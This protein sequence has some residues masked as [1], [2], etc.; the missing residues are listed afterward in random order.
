MA[1]GINQI[2][3]ISGQFAGLLLGGLLAAW[4]WRAVFWVNVPVGVF[5]TIW[6]YVKLHDT[7]VRRKARMDWWGNITFAL[8]L[9]SIL[10][11]I[12]Y[13]IQPY[14][15]HTMGWTSPLVLFC[16]LGGI[17]LHLRGDVRDVFMGW[18]RQQRP[19]LL[20]RYQELYR[21]GAYA[22]RE[23]RERLS[24]LV[25]RRG[26]DPGFRLAGHPTSQ[27]DTAPSEPAGR[28]EALF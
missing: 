1:L 3:G 24:R 4:D 8:G 6:A 11:G 2:A 21:R 19:D 16:L 20:P 22:P 23:E 10:V 15:G 7:G 12:T 5:G 28:Q 17:A 26:S 13:G 14:G 25:R 18:L 9:I 27:A